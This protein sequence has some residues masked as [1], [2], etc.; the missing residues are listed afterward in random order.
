MVF[1]ALGLTGISLL[2]GSTVYGQ[3]L[4]ATSN[5]MNNQLLYSPASAGMHAA[6][7]NFSTLTRFQFV[8]IKGAPRLGLGWLDYRTPNRKM[9]FGIGM[10]SFRQGGFSATDLHLNYSYSIRVSEKN[11]LSMGLRAGFTNARNNTNDYVIWDEN[12]PFE[13]LN[14]YTVVLPKFGTGFQWNGPSYYLNLSAPDLLTLDNNHL[15]IPDTVSFLQQHRN[16]IFMAGN[17]IKL[18]DLYNLRPSCMLQYYSPLNGLISRVN[19]T[20]E[21]KDYFSLGA[22]YSTAG[23]FGVN[24]GSQISRRMKFNYSYDLF[25]ASTRGNFIGAHEINLL[26]NMDNLVRRKTAEE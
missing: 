18:N 23:A 15:L 12:D 19:V 8:S 16:Y 9:A 11:K 3:Q 13:T 2:L 24:A 22:A 17:V 5:F 10:N 4:N 1:R 26:L 25:T 14:N 7:L 6:Q 21:I 20:F